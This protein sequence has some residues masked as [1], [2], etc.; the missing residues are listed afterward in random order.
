MGIELRFSN[1]RFC[2]LEKRNK[3]KEGKSEEPLNPGPWVVWDRRVYVEK[4]HLVTFI[5][6][7]I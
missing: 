6:I 7:S 5:S 2:V 3:R 4:V 1:S